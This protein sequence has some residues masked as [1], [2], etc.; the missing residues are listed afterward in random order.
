LPVS[1]T[2]WTPSAS[3]AELPPIAAAANLVMAMAVLPASAA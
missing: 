3:I 1:T 2:E